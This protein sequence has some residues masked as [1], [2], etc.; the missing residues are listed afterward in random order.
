MKT[1]NSNEKETSPMILI[2][3]TVRNLKYDEAMKIY[4]NIKK[5]KL[6]QSPEVLRIKYVKGGVVY[7]VARRPRENE[8]HEK[9]FIVNMNEPPPGVEYEIVPLS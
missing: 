6:V 9:E 7:C 2:S 4:R 8:V 1:L 5:K 3:W